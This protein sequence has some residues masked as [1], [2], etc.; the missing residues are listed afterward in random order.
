MWKMSLVT[1][2][3]QR[4]PVEAEKRKSPVRYG[5]EEET[6]FLL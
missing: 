5:F 4:K 1:T 2:E 3:E 6:V